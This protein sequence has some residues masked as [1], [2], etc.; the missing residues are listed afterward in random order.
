MIYFAVAMLVVAI[1]LAVPQWL[2]RRF[3]Q[4]PRSGERHCD[5]VTTAVSTPTAKKR[6][7]QTR[8]ERFGSK[9]NPTVAHQRCCRSDA[10]F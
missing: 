5:S 6:W 8:E 1:A 3:G 7:E 9:F 4:T 10:I 2:K